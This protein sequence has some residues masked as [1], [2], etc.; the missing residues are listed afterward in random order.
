MND[1]QDNLVRAGIDK[2]YIK[3]FTKLE[4][5]ELVKQ[6]KKQRSLQLEKLHEEQRK[7]DCLDYLIRKPLGNMSNN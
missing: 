7:I 6:L 2:K 1:F 4:G 3:A 5:A